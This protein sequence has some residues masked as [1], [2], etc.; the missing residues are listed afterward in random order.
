MPSTQNHAKGPEDDASPLPGGED[1]ATRRVA[2]MTRHSCS[3]TF[4]M[5]TNAKG[6]RGRDDLRAIQEYQAACPKPPSP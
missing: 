5:Y 2:R 6:R 4:L 1:E 3:Q